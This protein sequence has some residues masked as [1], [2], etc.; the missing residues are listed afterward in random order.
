MR[1]ND[2]I[3]SEPNTYID[4]QDAAELSGFA[5]RHLRK[6]IKSDQIKYFKTEKGLMIC[7]A[8]VQRLAGQQKPFWVT[9]PENALFT[10]T[11]P[12]SLLLYTDSNEVDV[13]HP[14]EAF[15]DKVV[16]G[17][18][19]DWMR[20]MPSQCIQ[21]VVT[22]PP[23]WGVRKYP[24]SEKIE[25]AD[26]SSINLGEEPSVDGYVAHTLEVFR[27]LK[28]VLRDDGTIWWNLGDTYQTRAYLRESS[29]ERLR[30]FEGDRNDTWSKYPNKRYSSGHS[31][32][33]DKDL[34]LVPF[35]VAIGAEHLGFYVRSIIVWNKENTIP[36]PTIDRPTT[37]HEYILLLTKSRFYKYYEDQETEAS[38]TGEVIKR[39]NG[40]RTFEMG[41]KR[42]LRTVWQFPTSSRHGDHTAAFPLELPLR[43]LRLSTK[44]GDLVFD[45]FAGSGTTLAAAKILTCR[46]FGCDIVEEFVSESE[47]RLLAPSKPLN[48]K[49]KNTD[50]RGAR[51]TTRSEV[52]QETLLDRKPGYKTR[53]K[54]TP[55]EQQ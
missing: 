34:T 19:I 10:S 30:A 47:R 55:S 25:W 2:I 4:V 26:G 38:I 51:D 39:N 32:L 3:P 16:H 46:Y 54:P 9:L 36:E 50:N 18:C 21:S 31:Y 27:H 41:T 6:L 7:W 15:Y 29:T 35:L 5:V 11:P 44:P 17:N 53:K 45:P 8:D 52:R 48:G 49:Q 37:A 13:H 42:K 43:C 24:D 33:K 23:Y 12:A 14:L 40:K 22:S 28:R 1:S 20:R